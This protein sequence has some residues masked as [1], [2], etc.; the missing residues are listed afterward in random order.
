MAKINYE[1]LAARIMENIGGAENVKTVTHCVTRLRFYLKD[2][3]IVNDEALKKLP[4]VLGVVYGNGQYQIILGEHLFVTFDHIVKNYPVETEAVIDE[5]LDKELVNRAQKK[6]FGYYFEK[7]ITFMGQALTPFITVVYGAGMLRVVLSLASYFV[8][9]V[10]GSTTYQLF[11]FMSQTPFYFMPILVAYGTSRVLKSNPAFAI[12]MAAAL[13]YPDFNAMMAAGEPVAMFGL[14]VHLGTYGNSLLPGI[15]SAILCAYLEKF[16][17]R[18]VPGVLKS[19]FA[20]LCVFLIGFPVTVLVLGPVGSIVGSWIVAGIVYLQAHVGGLAPG[21]IAAVQ[22]FLVM[23]GVNMLLVGPMTELLARV[24][25][26]NVFRP[27]WILH[28]I[29]EGGACFAV[30]VRTKDKE[31]RTAAL[32]AGVGAFLSGVSEPALYGINL[33]LKKPMIGLVIGGFAGGAAAGVM[34]ARAYT[35]GYSSVLGVVIFE[36]TMIA[37]LTG[38]AVAFAVSFLITLVLYNGK[39]VKDR[40]EKE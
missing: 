1:D 23:M 30:A 20:P 6:S 3:G 34:G 9:S 31:L 15:F 22:P 32:S 18:V 7:A 8:P 37:I 40:T 29:A 27:G 36:D 10:T 17:Y 4:G 39:E 35:M 11:N 5:N 38:I 33:R 25:F 2:R 24:G 12:A 14:P 16:F 21:I 28:N 26:D 19:V 13:L